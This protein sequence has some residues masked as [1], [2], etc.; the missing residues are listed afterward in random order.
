MERALTKDKG[1]DGL[2]LLRMQDFFGWETLPL[3]RLKGLIS[4]VS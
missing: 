4:R 2:T 1:Y 3:D